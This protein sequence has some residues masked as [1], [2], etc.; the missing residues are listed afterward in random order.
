MSG[1]HHNVLFLSLDMAGNDVEYGLQK[2][3][4][5]LNQLDHKLLALQKD[6]ALLMRE[7]ERDSGSGPICRAI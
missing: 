7:I 4:K 1:V 2:I 6:I 5:E 3:G